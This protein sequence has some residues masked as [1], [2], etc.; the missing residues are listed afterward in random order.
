V[1]SVEVGLD[2]SSADLTITEVVLAGGVLD[3]L[4]L[5]FGAAVIDAGGQ[6]AS[7]RW[8]LDSTPPFSPTIPAGSGLLLATVLVDVAP[9]I[10]EGDT[11]QVDFVDGSGTPPTSNRVRSG[12]ALLVPTTAS[13]LVHVTLGDFIAFR[14]DDAFGGAIDHLVEVMASNASN[15]QGFSTVVSFDPTLLQCAGVDVIDTITE[16]VGVEFVEEII[17]NTGGYAILGVLLD[18]IPPF[19]GQV[20]PVTGFDLPIANYRFDISDQVQ[21]EVFTPIRFED[22]LGT[23]AIENIFV[24]GNQ[25]IQP[26]KTDTFLRVVGLVDFLRGDA[27]RN[28]ELGLPDIII[29]FLYVTNTLATCPTCPEVDCTSA[30]D[31]NDNGLVDLA[32][33]IY[34]GSHLYLA[35]PP[36]PPPYPTEGPDP[37]PDG[38]TCE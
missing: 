25:S 18:I 10:D 29:N 34:L 17:E 4:T 28:L 9:G 20:I 21:G 19:Q 35:G 1:E 12:G 5:E 32:D 38:L 15:V 22:G 6:E 31:V 7:L 23:P 33:G 13:G 8:I 3:G 14:A 27:D 36:P 24:V 11:V 30:L 26:E 2:V 37:T 16:A